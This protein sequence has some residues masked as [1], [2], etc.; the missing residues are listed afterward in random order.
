MPACRVETPVPGDVTGSYGPLAEE[1]I[2]V[3]LGDRLRPWQR[4]ALN[5]A[6]EHRADGS[7][8]WSEVLLTVARQSGKTI[9]LRGLCGWRGSS[10]EVFGEPQTVLSVANLKETALL[11]WRPVARV[12]G[13]WGA[14][15][16]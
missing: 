16:R 8:R 13:E 10:S 2:A 5:R 14:P 1:W 7:L 11:P 3:H 4:Y 15:P 6:L 12:A 9:L